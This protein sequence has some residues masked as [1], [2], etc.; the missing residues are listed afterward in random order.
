MKSI[1]LT[2]FRELGGYQ[3]SNGKKIKE[4]YL[5][6]GRALRTNDP[7]IISSIEDLHID[8]IFDFRD[9]DNR[10]HEPDISIKGAKYYP[11]GVLESLGES[12]D[13]NPIDVREIEKTLEG[14]TWTR[15][16]FKAALAT[17]ERMY[18]EMPFSPGYKAMFDA[19]SRHEKIYV[20]CTGGKDRTGVACML[21]LWALGASKRTILHD[22][23]LSNKCRRERN[24]W[25]IKRVLQ[26]SK[27][28]YS[29]YYMN[30]FMFCRKRQFKLTFKAIFAKY[31]N[32]YEYFDKTFGISK[33]TIEDWRKFYLE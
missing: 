12:M 9:S 14:E 13:K 33:E 17:Y 16:D 20:H 23:R 11:C 27:K 25:R 2:N 32:L 18:L 30:K 24:I 8:S 31:D 5:F 15:K 26:M 19:L 22:Y 3:T 10:L 4:G 6:R 21:I 29:V 1:P 28:L 7:S